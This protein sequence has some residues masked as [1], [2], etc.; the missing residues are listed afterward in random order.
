[1]YGVLGTSLCAAP[2]RAL[3]AL[4]ASSGHLISE[5]LFLKFV[6]SNWLSQL[7]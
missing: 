1:M 3:R 5:N 6:I 4:R 7:V 2:L